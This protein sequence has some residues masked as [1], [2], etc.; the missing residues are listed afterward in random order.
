MRPVYIN[1]TDDEGN[2]T[3]TYTACSLKTGM[4]DNIFDIAERAESLNTD[5]VSIGQAKDFYKDLKSLILAVFKY[6]FSFDE[7]NENVE[8]EELMKV[9]QDICGNIGGELRKN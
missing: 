8:Q 9:F 6:Q 5:S 4:M 2:K 7:L 3:K 1:F